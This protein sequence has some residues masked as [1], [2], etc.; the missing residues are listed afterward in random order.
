MS[1][2]I[3][4]QKTM[5]N[6]VMAVADQGGGLLD[7]F[8]VGPLDT[9]R[10]GRALYSLNIEAVHQRY[11]DTV[12]NPVTLPGE[13]GCERWPETYRHRLTAVSMS[14]VARYKAL[15]CLIYQCAEGSVI[16]TAQYEALQAIK[17]RLAHRI[18][19]KLPEYEAIEWGA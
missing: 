4:P 14:S 1:A 3:V 5:H 9:D 18:I 8:G 7:A 6:A 12:D 13:A 2:F 10:L 16:E 17:A 11:P 19:S 15:S